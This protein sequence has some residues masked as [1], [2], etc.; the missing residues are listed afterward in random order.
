MESITIYEILK[1]MGFT[2]GTIV[3]IGAGI[4]KAV[5]Y[6]VDRYDNRKKEIDTQKT[7]QALHAKNIIPRLIKALGASMDCHKI[8]LIKLHNGAGK[9]RPEKN[10]LIS[11]MGEEYFPTK[12]PHPEKL[13]SIRSDY[14]NFLVDDRY[15]EHMDELANEKVKFMSVDMV[16]SDILQTI[17]KAQAVKMGVLIW[18]GALPAGYLF[19]SLHYQTEKTSFTDTEKMY[20][21][22]ALNEL[23]DLYNMDKKQFFRVLK[24]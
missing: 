6:F 14:Q 13:G 9:M 1:Q 21:Q 22:T 2:F 3:A 4:W 11:V 12:A 5:K 16:K 18:I 7:L 10:F 19:I 24:R 15:F 17:W 8:L 23:R 20:I